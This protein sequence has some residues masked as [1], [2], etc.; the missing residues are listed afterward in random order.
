MLLYSAA[1]PISH[2]SPWGSHSCKPRGIKATRTEGVC[3]NTASKSKLCLDIKRLNKKRLTRS[4]PSHTVEA[5]KAISLA[6]L[7]A[8]LR[9][10]LFPA[11]P[12][13]HHNRCVICYTRNPGP[14]PA[15]TCAVGEMLIAGLRVSSVVL[16]LNSTGSM[17][18]LAGMCK[19]NRGLT[20]NS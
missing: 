15:R 12:S 10:A 18:L 7:H 3:F 20:Q 2:Q 14:R 17:W 19:F 6:S 13:K 5:F 16:S 1:F 9:S 4:H 8:L 11:P